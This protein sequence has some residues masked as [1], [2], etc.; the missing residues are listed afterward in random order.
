MADVTMFQLRSDV[1]EFLL[2][3]LP[4]GSSEYFLIRTV[5]V[6]VA[7]SAHFLVDLSVA[8]VIKPDCKYRGGCFW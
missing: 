4:N 1:W 5:T 8:P 7:V 3:A 6:V 2:E